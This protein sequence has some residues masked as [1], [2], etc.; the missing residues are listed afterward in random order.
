MLKAT[1]GVVAASAFCATL[2]EG[3]GTTVLESSWAG[4][5]FHNCV[6]GMIAVNTV[7]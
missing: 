4:E 7:C 1:A 3:K 2:A 5:V 6:L